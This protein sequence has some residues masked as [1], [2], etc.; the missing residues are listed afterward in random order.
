MTQGELKNEYPLIYEKVKEYILRDS[1]IE[2]TLDLD[3]SFKYSSSGFEI[4]FW[5]N[6]NSNRN[7]AKWKK[8]YP[9]LFINIINLEIWA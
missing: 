1:Y 3:S 6:L 4:S 7:I 8:K 5:Y 2:D 9:E